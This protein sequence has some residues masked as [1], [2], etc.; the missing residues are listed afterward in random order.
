MSKKSKVTIIEF[1]RFT[2]GG[3][4]AWVKAKVD[5]KIIEIKKPT[6]EVPARLLPKHD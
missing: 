6:T 4:H 1:I 5:G 3:F 2:A